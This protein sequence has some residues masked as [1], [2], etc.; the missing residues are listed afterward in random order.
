MG[1]PYQTGLLTASKGDRLER[2]LHG[3]QCFAYHLSKQK[4]TQ[5][6]RNQR[7]QKKNTNQ[8]RDKRINGN[9]PTPFLFL[10]LLFFSL[11]EVEAGPAAV[12]LNAV[13]PDAHHYP[14]WVL[15]S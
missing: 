10:F 2:P 4:K 7:I 13:I 12:L 15:D 3:G 9:K 14:V 8:Q 1:E 6:L 5:M 11:G